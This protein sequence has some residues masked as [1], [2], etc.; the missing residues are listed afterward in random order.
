MIEHGRDDYLCMA[1]GSSRRGPKARGVL[2]EDE[3]DA[4]LNLSRRKIDVCLLSQDGEIV[5]ERASTPGADGLP[6]WRA[7]LACTR[8][9]FAG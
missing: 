3:M 2:A 7:A 9:P 5:D 4:G 1:I 6:G 8:R